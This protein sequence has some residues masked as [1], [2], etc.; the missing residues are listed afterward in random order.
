[1]IKEMEISVIPNEGSRLE[2]KKVDNR[3]LAKV[4]VAFSNSKGGRIQIGITD[5]KN[6]VGTDATPEGIARIT[7]ENCS[8]SI[9]PEITKEEYDGKYILN[10]D[11][12]VGK[13][14]PYSYHGRYLVRISS[15]NDDA[16]I[17][18]LIDLILKGPQK[19][20]ILQRAK[21]DD[22]KYSISASASPCSDAGNDRAIERIN[23]LIELTNNSKGELAILDTIRILGEL[24][25]MIYFNKKILSHVIFCLPKISTIHLVP[26]HPEYTPSEELFVTIINIVERVF[27]MNTIVAEKTD[28][29]I[30]VL[31][32][33]FRIALGC[34]WAG[35]ENQVIR[36]CQIIS[37]PIGRDRQLTK[38][39]EKTLKKI[40]K[41]ATEKNVFEPRKMG[42]MFTE[43]IQD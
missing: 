19:G 26:N 12:S 6:I 40:E 33:F 2:Y 9:N 41:C 30:T 14:P 8:P 10:V 36:I 4:L 37:D 15:T 35:Y 34:I 38:Y 31:N 28:T 16:N 27:Q 32:V 11:V 43:K 39:L 22:L 3:G 17:D 21:L 23:E 18:E 24:S 7:R 42:M 25:E 13:Y 29:T 5:D 20:T 1:M